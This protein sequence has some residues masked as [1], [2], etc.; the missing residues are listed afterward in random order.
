[1]G[2]KTKSRTKDDA[3]AF[4]LKTE[5]TVAINSHETDCKRSKIF[6]RDTKS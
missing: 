1:M 5:R 6:A 3:K 4:I 2:C